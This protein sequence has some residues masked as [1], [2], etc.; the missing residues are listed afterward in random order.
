LLGGTDFDYQAFLDLGQLHWCAMAVGCCQAVLDYVIPYANERKAFGEP[1]SHRQS[2]A[3]MIANI[4]IELESMRLLLW[5]ASS[6]AQQGENFHKE[7]FLARQLS[8]KE[9]CKLLL[10]VYKSSAGT[11]IPKSTPLNAGIAIYV[12]WPLCMACTFKER[13]K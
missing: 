10:M 5:R 3:F 6:L 9:A 13:L 12:E 2:V 8:R 11:V 7:A 1:I 4:A